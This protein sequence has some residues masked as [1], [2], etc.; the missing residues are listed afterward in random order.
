MVFQAVQYSVCTAFFKSAAIRNL[1]P[2]FVVDSVT[3]SLEVHYGNLR[4][5]TPDKKWFNNSSNYLGGFWK[6]FVESL[7]ILDYFKMSK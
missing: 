5:N 6:L 1:D 4:Y 3:L 2:S 7:Q